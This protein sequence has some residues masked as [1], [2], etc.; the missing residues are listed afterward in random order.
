M[1]MNKLTQ[2]SQ[3]ALQAAQQKAVEFG[4][5]QLDARHLLLGLIEPAGGLIRRL[6]ERMDV[7][8]DAVTCQPERAQKIVDAL[9]HLFTRAATGERVRAITQ[10]SHAALLVAQQFA[11]HFGYCRVSKWY[12]SCSGRYLGMLH[13]WSGT[14]RCCLKW[15]SRFRYSVF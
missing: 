1:D 10:E 12:Y 13:G 11:Q 6:L 3:E 14:N 15:S 5:Q 9:G 7:P 2:K 8:V 4:H